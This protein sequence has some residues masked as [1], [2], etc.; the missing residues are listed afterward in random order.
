MASFNRIKVGQTL[1][2]V[3]RQR[4]GNTTM[5]RLAVHTVLV[6]EIDPVKRKVF[7]VWNHFNA[8]EWYNER[9]ISRWKVN[10]PKADPL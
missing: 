4:M 1:Y 8:P 6:K 2:T 9:Q 10:K 7:A 5:T 3:T